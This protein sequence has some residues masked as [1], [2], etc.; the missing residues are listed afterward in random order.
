MP[1]SIR[2]FRR[3]DR[4]QKAKRWRRSSRGVDNQVRRETSRRSASVLEAHP[5]DPPIVGRGDELRHARAR[6]KFDVRLPFDLAAADKLKRRARQGELI[7]SK[8]AL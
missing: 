3:A 2:R 6:S 5:R 1:I 8:V 4:F 7:E